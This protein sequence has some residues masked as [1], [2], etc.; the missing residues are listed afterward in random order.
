MRRLRPLLA[1]ALLSLPLLAG[2]TPEAAAQTVSPTYVVEGQT[3]T[4]T[5]SGFPS[6]WTGQAQI[7]ST[8]GSSAFIVN[9]CAALSL[10]PEADGCYS[11]VAWDSTARTFTFDLQIIT[12]AVDDDDETLVLNLIDSDSSSRTAMVTIDILESAPVV[13][14]EITIAPKTTGAVTEGGSAEWTVTASAAPAADLT[15]NLSVANPPNASF[16]ATTSATATITAGTTT[17]DYTLATTNDST[18]EP[19]GPV[20]VTVQ[21]GEGYTIGSASSAS[22]TVNDNDATI[23]TMV[24]SVANV[25][26]GGTR[27][28][29]VTLSRGGV[30]RGLYNGESLTVPLTFHGTAVRG[31]DY[32]MACGSARGVTCANLNSGSAT[33]TFTG[34][35]SGTTASSVRLTLTA[36][37]DGLVES[38]ESVNINLGTLNANS[39]TNLGGGATGQ[40]SFGQFNILDTGP[41]ITIAPK[42]A[43]AVTEGGNAVWTVTAS[44]APSSNLTVMLSVTNPPGANFTGSVTNSVQILSGAT[45]ADYTIQTL[46]DSI[47][48]PSGPVTVTVTDSTGYTVGTPS[49]AQV[50]V[51]DND[52]TRVTLAG[53]ATDVTEGGTK[54]FTVTLN[55]GLYNGE[56]LEVPL[57]FGGTAVRGT[58]GDY[59]VTCGGAAGVACA[60]LDSG[61]ATVTFTGPI[62]GQSSNTI[63]L[64]LTARN[65]GVSGESPESV[66]IGLGPLNSNSGTNLGG[67]ASGTDSFADFD[68]LNQDLA[69]GEFKV[70]FHQGTVLAPERT[71]VAVIS[72]TLSPPP[73]EDGRLRFQ[74]Q[75]LTATLGADFVP[76]WSIPVRAGQ[77]RFA[78]RVPLVRD[79]LI[80]DSELVR[81]TRLDPP[82][83]VTAASAD[84][85]IQNSDGPIM[86]G[87]PTAA[88]GDPVRVLVRMATGWVR[89][90]GPLV[91]RVETVE[92][93]GA[94]AATEGTD[95]TAVARDV[96]VP[97]GV[98]F[99]WVEIPTAADGDTAAETFDVQ[100]R[101]VSYN[102]RTF[103]PTTPWSTVSATILPAGTPVPNWPGISI[104]AD[105]AGIQEGEDA[106][107]T[108]SAHPKPENALMV[109]VVLRPE[110]GDFLGTEHRGG[111]L[112]ALISPA[113]G[114]GTLT[115]PTLEDPSNRSGRIVADVIP[116][117]FSKV[118]AVMQSPP[119]RTGGFRSTPRAVLTV[120]DHPDVQRAVLP[121]A[122]TLTLSADAGSATEG[123]T[124]SFTITADKAPQ[125]DVEV[126]VTAEERM[127]AGSEAI[128]VGH[129]LPVLLKSG[130]TS[131]TWSFTAW[132]DDEARAHGA[133]EARIDPD[134]GAH[135]SYKV[136]DPSTAAMVL[137]DDDGTQA[138]PA[139]VTV[140]LAAEKT[141]VA[142]ANGETKWTM[143]LSRALAAGETVT[144]PYTVSGGEPG[145]HWSVVFRS[146]DNGPGVSRHGHGKNGSELRFT[147]GGQ[148]ATM[149]LI[150]RPTTDTVE[151]TIRV[152]FG[153]G[154]R[155]PSSTGIAAGIALGASSFDVVII[156]DDGTQQPPPVVEPAVT[157]AAG[158]SPV[159]EGGDATFTLTASPAPHAPL[160]VTVAVAASGDYGVTAGS[161]TVTI[162]TGGS[163][164][165][166]L[167]TADDTI[168]EP[169]GSA[170][171]TVKAG[172]G[173]TVGSPASGSIVIRD[174]DLPPPVITIAAKVASITEGGDAVFTIAADRAPDADLPVSIAV[175][176]TGGGDHVAAQH[177][178][179]RIATIRQGTTSAEITVPTVNDTVDEPDGTVTATLKGGSGYT[180]GSASSA[181]VK[182]VDD[183]SSS[184]PML[185]I[186]DATVGEGTMARVTVR[187]SAPS[188]VPVRVHV[189]AREASPVSARAGE[190]FFAY[191]YRGGNALVFR[192][193]QTARNVG[194]YVFDDSH[195]DGGET[196]EVFLAQA[197]GAAVADGT[198]IV[199]IEN[200]DPLPAAWLK[201]F[202]RTVA[203]Q[204]LDGIAARIEAPRTAGMQGTL[205]GQALNFAPGDGDT[206]GPGDAQQG[207]SGVPAASGDAALAMAGI[208]RSFGA[209]ASAP[210]GSGGAGPF[211]TG[212]TGFGGTQ[213]QSLAMQSRTMTARDAL[214]G[215]SFSLTGERDGMGGSL[216]FWGRASQGSF[217]GTERGDGT[218]I[219]LDGTVTTGLLGADYARGTWLLGL[220]LAQSSAEG[221]YAAI[222][223]GSP[224][225]EVGGETPVLCDGGVR[226]GDGS[227]E[228]SLTAAIPYAAWQA[229]ERLKL[230][231]AA[232]HGTGEVTVK[233]APGGRYSADTSWSM[234]A[235]GVRGDLLDA[236]IDGGGGPALAVTSDALWARTSSEKTRD[237]AASDSDV[238]RLRLGLEGS[239]RIALEGGGSVTPKLETGIR[240]D[241]G[242]AESGFGVELGGGV[243]WVD[244]DLGLSL[245][246][247]GRT[248]LSHEDSDFEDRG[249]SAS[250]AW[251][252]APA[253]QR[254]P[255]LSLRQDWGGQA[256]G[257][258][259]ALFAPDPL[260]ER[261]GDGATPASRWTMEAAYGFPAFGGRFTG[262]PHVGLGLS[263]GARDYSVG[264]RLTREAATAPDLSFGIRATR[265]ENDTAEAEHTV[266]FEVRTTW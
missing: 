118:E 235:A 66:V 124:V 33:V 258:L 12:D 25:T 164:T 166:T 60:N 130:A 99:A 61:S 3:E 28:A 131:V 266:G 149:V 255:S 82:A 262:S 208:A 168:D 243:A 161:R 232:G 219:T 159:T 76:V 203:Q 221:D 37:N 197:E 184:L 250:L 207:A 39:G 260:A 128:A 261:A 23:V 93:S 175:S 210:A 103:P 10:L 158:T 137:L 244:P 62:S 91:V 17:A 155:A 141:S 256:T 8:S 105:P 190:D 41:K 217:D 187:L 180:P 177:E 135:E 264:W 6:S 249:Y 231:G 46:N 206:A 241:G 13:I 162:P 11:N 116:R 136:G 265:R 102:G 236:P 239:W 143:T 199:T 216:A 79:G 81:I 51:L 213:G 259:D 133:I 156:D 1:A 50:R 194:F 188:E 157:V 222:G 238:T 120:T 48:E 211:G 183:D 122:P 27:L 83:G 142:E 21:T 181:S 119:Y 49:S 185:S 109:S 254:G 191:T 140:S 240:H 176:E 54:A 113:T 165:L 144:V 205:A 111:E 107:F 152:A 170:S 138:P 97:A 234:A 215:S 172:N 224:C 84:V 87:S 22:V 198:G 34:P 202:G 59:T 43:S 228:A 192:P 16:T 163:A 218:D 57:T 112:V 75:P 45:T 35:S 223:G 251:D 42:T 132:S 127:G 98:P 212:G 36:I 263:T 200:D 7:D 86:S 214:L 117:Q 63:T 55:R 24:G 160:A 226:A 69:T 9:D 148:V 230:W 129:V 30:D 167:A 115:V 209:D 245:D 110:G 257:G 126:Y 74:Y 20:T 15:V 96:T 65:D 182:V 195:D 171:V 19:N 154:T 147:Q 139:P 253:T 78:F 68:I 247:S 14:P 178:G 18:D 114:T 169:D 40:E 104:A 229:S 72:G 242:D 26:E 80:E 146:S 94:G 173:Y 220:V 252:P 225:P 123:D 56:V 121:G 186:D 193:G 151:R 174:D 108:L 5:I 145:A 237:L 201:R 53:D 73:T 204:T 106:V 100:Y 227:I 32:T 71:G 153:T 125:Q 77:T 134:P 85:V 2:L 67:G 70:T 95:Y 52:A 233:T 44:S 31:T 196:F 64:T 246:L 38:N 101:P 150:G 88:A 92:G 29:T 90:K 89:A 179:A 4:I 189:G 47:D 248:L 58:G